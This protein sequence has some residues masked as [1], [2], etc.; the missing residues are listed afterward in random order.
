LEEA[1]PTPE[2]LELAAELER[3]YKSPEWNL[4]R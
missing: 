1:P 4:R 2:E 3:K